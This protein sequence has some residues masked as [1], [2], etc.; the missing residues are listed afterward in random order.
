MSYSEGSSTT[1]LYILV[2]CVESLGESEGREEEERRERG[3]RKEREK[4]GERKE[5]KKRRDRKRDKP[6]LTQ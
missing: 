2:I 6:V 1:H 5:G 3:G 4:R